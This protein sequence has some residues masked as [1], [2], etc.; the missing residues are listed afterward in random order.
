MKKIKLRTDEQSIEDALDATPRQ[1]ASKG[2]IERVTQEASESIASRTKEA[3]INLRMSPSDL[4][5]LRA[6][7]GRQGIGYQTLVSSVV[8][9]YVTGELMEKRALEEVVRV[10]RKSRA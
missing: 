6:E 8:H 4:K 10:M 7:A 3:R 9:K 2:R 1:F 5:L